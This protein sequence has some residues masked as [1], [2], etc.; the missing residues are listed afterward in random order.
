MSLSKPHAPLGDATF[1]DGGG[2][3]ARLIRMTDWSTSPLGPISDWPQSLKTTVSLCLASN[4]PINIIWGGASIPRSTTTDTASS[5][6][7][8]TRAPWGR[9]TTAEGRVGIRWTVAR[10]TDAPDVEI[11]WTESGGPLVGLPGR[12]GFGS[13]LIQQ[14]IARVLDGVIDLD[15]VL[16][17]VRCRMRFPASGKIEVPLA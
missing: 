5:A 11:T 3:M 15:F 8:L 10:G 2:E 9:A 17:G 16:A 14:A 12:R 13:R 7:R 1:L 6:E 4:F